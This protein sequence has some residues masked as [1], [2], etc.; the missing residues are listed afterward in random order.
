[1]VVATSMP[2]LTIFLLIAGVL[3]P[4]GCPHL[5]APSPGP[6]VRDF[7]PIGSYGGH[8]GIDIAAPV[9]SPATAAETG[10][11][12]FAGE[13]AGVLSVTIHHGGGLRTSYSYLSEIAVV[14][15]QAVARGDVVGS[16]G[17]DHDMAA[18][19]FSVR[20]GD[21]YHDPV[22]WLGCFHAPQPGLSLVPSPGA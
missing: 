16:S 22:G 2:I 3:F 4:G 8:W 5:D 6:I 9:G 19:H 21:T 10:T 12:T 1:M 7:A 20:V 18:I 14:R 17:L 13:V 11:V 15:G